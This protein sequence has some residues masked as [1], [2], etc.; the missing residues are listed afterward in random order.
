MLTILVDN[1]IGG[2]NTFIA[3]VRSGTTVKC[4]GRGPSTVIPGPFGR[5]A[6]L[7]RSP[8]KSV[9]QPLAESATECRKRLTRINEA[10]M[11][12][13]EIWHEITETYTLTETGIK[14][15]R[16]LIS[17]FSAEEVASAMTKSVKYLDFAD[18]AYTA[19]SVEKAW[20]KVG[21]ICTVERLAKDDPHIHEIY[22]IRMMLMTRIPSLRP[23]VLI[24]NLT[25]LRNAGYSAAEIRAAMEPVRYWT[26]F[27]DT[28]TEM[29]GEVG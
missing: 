5:R 24:R 27:H 4:R 23:Y 20:N 12:C 13:A 8:R 14:G 1:G 22:K 26:Q 28:L 10:V 7:K 16:K 15:L 3:V 6:Q 18:G 2:Y 9:V 19:E 29:L 17:R 11:Q 21:A 25:D